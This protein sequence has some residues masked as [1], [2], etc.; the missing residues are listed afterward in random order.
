MKDLSTALK[1]LADHNRLKILCLL[2]QSQ[3]CVRSLACRLE[4]TESAVSQHLKV[5]RENGLVEGHKCGYWTHY[6]IC[7]EAL[8]QVLARMEEALIQSGK[9]QE[10]CE[11]NNQDSCPENGTTGGT[12]CCHKDRPLRP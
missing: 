5:L 9:G 1:A 8:Q 3:Y 4:I 12:R 11:G 2:K 6:R 7:R 10:P